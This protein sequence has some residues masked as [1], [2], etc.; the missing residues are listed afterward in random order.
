M[1]C[2]KHK[3][4]IKT[5]KAALAREE[6]GRYDFLIEYIKCS[7]EDFLLSEANLLTVQTVTGIKVAPT[8]HG[9]RYGTWEPVFRCKGRNPSERIVRIRIPKRN[10]GAE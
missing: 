2:R 4:A 9:L 3:N 5:G 7:I 6:Y 1:N 8:H 10:T